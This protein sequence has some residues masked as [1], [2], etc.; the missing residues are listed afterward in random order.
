MNLQRNDGPVRTYRTPEGNL[1]SV[2]TILKATRLQRDVIALENWRRRVGPMKAAQITKEASNVGHVMHKSI[3]NWIKN[4]PQTTSDN[5]VHRIGKKMGTTIIDSLKEN[6]TNVWGNE[7]S[8]FYPD[9]YA[10]T[11]DLIGEWKGRP[12][13]IDFKQADK[14]KKREWIT[15]YFIQTCAYGMAHNH[16]YDTDIKG[17]VILIC[18]RVDYTLQTYEAMDSE[19]EG[20]CLMWAKKLDEYYK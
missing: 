19:Y 10:G 9:L 20:Y 2:T 5:L 8:V 12:A 1:P 17:S 13:V 14:P 16:L 18:N 4:K 11:A 7:V 3:E 6:M 15:D